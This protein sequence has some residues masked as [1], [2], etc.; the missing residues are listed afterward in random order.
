VPVNL[1]YV[2]FPRLPWDLSLPFH[3]RG[4]DSFITNRPRLPV[5]SHRDLLGMTAR[6][7]LSA[8]PLRD[9]MDLSRY[10]ITRCAAAFFP[11][12]HPNIRLLTSHL[13][14]VRDACSHLLTFAAAVFAQLLSPAV[15]HILR[16]PFDPPLFILAS[17]ASYRSSFPS[18]SASIFD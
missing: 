12:S 14:F 11:L 5:S 15:P 9:A 6:G 18:S 2:A 16:G 8:V 3:V 10:H 7:S 4:N 17:R 1:L 13:E